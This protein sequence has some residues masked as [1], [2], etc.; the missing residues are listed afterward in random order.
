VMEIGGSYVEA[1]EPSILSRLFGDGRRPFV[2]LLSDLRKAE[3]DER[4]AAVVLRIRNLDVGWGKAEEI[5]SALKEMAASGRRTVAFLEVE[6]LGANLEYYVATGAEAIH[7]MPA[8]RSALVGLAA[9]YLFLGGMFEKLGIRLEF[10]RIGAYKTATDLIAGTAMS[11]AHREMAESLLDSINA[12]FTGGIAEGRNL[13]PEFVSEVIDQAPMTSE[14]MQ[15]L[16]LID[17]ISHYDELIESLGGGPVIEG[18]DYASVDPSSVGFDPV[19]RFALVYGAGLVVTGEG[20]STRTGQPVLASDTVS[21]ALKEAAED[22]DV[23]AIIFRIDSPGGSPLAADIVWRATQEARK[24]GKPLIASFSDVA[25]S[26]GYYVA[27]GA[28]AIVAPAGALTG[29]IGVYVLRPMLRGL[30]DKLGIGFAALTRG[31]HA[32]LLLA[33]RPLTPETRERLRAEVES[34]YELFVQRVAAGRDL[35][36]ER[37]DEVGRGRVWTGVQAVESG[38]VDEVGGLRTAVARAKASLGL[39]PDADVALVTFPQPKSIAEQIDDALRG[40]AAARGSELP[41]PRIAR[42]L[43]RWLGAVPEGAPAL[44][45]PFFVEIR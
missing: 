41:L 38:L 10:E 5:R 1:A 12:Q 28:D 32:D 16:G 3:R 35:S 40:L 17:G 11:E 2:G 37:V 13:T 42:S 30:L 24:S 45:P 7:A 26:G 20:S 14:E 21:A 18:S 27:A 25:A 15:A 31:A 44:L 39:D 43:L 8:S 6:S 22:G 19:A 36:S 9:E 29:S 34:V 33:S 4:L 23:S